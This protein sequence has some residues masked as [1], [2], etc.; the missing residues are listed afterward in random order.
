MWSAWINCSSPDSSRLSAST[1]TALFLASSANSTSTAAD[2]VPSSVIRR[3]SAAVCFFSAAR[4]DRRS[5]RAASQFSCSTSAS[6]V[7]MRIASRSRSFVFSP[8]D[9]R[10]FENAA[11][12]LLA[13]HLL[14]TRALSSFSTTASSARAW[15][16]SSVW[17]F[18][19]SFGSC[20]KIEAPQKRTAAGDINRRVL[21]S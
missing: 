3:A 9:E 19:H 16:E 5:A 4:R 8:T 21:K 14:A 10:H 1:S 6:S 20:V 12:V 17:S 13:S 15:S 2:L 11:D 7:S 18:V